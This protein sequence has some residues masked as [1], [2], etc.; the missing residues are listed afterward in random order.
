MPTTGQCTIW[1]GAIRRRDMSCAL[2]FPMLLVAAL[3]AASVTQAQTFSVLHTFKGAPDGVTPQGDLLRDAA[4]NIYGTT[5]AGGLKYGVVFKLDATGKETIL[6]T[7]KGGADGGSPRAGM[8]RDSLGSFYGT[9]YSGGATGDGVVFKLTGRTEVV[10]HSF[11]GPDG[12]HPTGALIRDKSGNLYGTTFYGGTAACSCGTVFKIDS[13]GN[14]TVLYSFTGS[15]DGK[16][17]EGKL[18]LDGVGNLYGT[19]SEGGFVNCDNGIHGCGVV[20]KVDPSGNETVLYAFNGDY[21][22][23][24][25]GGEPLAGLVRDSAGNFYGTAFSAGD[26]S[27]ACALN[28]GCGV[29]FKL[30]KNDLESA[31]YTFTT[32]TDGANPSGDLVRDPATGDLYGTTKLGGQGAGF[33]GYGTVFKVDPTGAE[34]ILYSFTGNNDGAGPVAG[35]VLDSSGNLYGT[36]AF[37][38]AFGHGVVFKVTH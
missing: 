5:S 34:T 4:G 28:H 33:T 36:A 26:P 13:S 8:V 12:A 18:F 30:T 29:V 15:T 7:F 32:G 19:A 14:E 1:I 35:L 17:P 27:R 6:Y 37:G 16:F 21:L 11:G 9:T 2:T 31:L 25:D 38:G 24:E 22:T 20:F 3:L 10:L 23:K